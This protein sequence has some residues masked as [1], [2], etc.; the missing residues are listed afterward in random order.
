MHVRLQSSL[1]WSGTLGLVAACLGG[2][3]VFAY[4]GDRPLPRALEPAAESALPAVSL[5]ATMDEAQRAC[6]WEIEHH[7]LLLN[8]YGFRPWA[9]ALSRAD[10]EGLRGIC[11]ADF[12]GNILESAQVV[13]ANS[14]FVDVVRHE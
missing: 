3:L 12:Q 13:R 4:R 6:L 5:Q 10:G 8:R 1:S 9:D 11:A 14:D 7:G 2:I